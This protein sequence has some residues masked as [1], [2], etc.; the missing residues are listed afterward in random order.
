MRRDLSRDVTQNVRRNQVLIKA[1][2]KAGDHDANDNAW[3]VRALLKLFQKNILKLG[4]WRTALSIDK[5]MAKSYA[6]TS[7]KQFISGKPIRFGLKLWGF[8]TSDGFVLCFDLYC[9]KNWRIGVKFS[10]CA[11]G[12][13]VVMDL[14]EP[15]FNKTAAGKISQFRLYFD[16][17]FTNLDLIVHLRKLG[18]KCTRTIRDNRVKDVIDK[19]APRGEYDVKH[20]KNRGMNYMTVVDSKPVSI[21]TTASGVT[22]EKVQFT[23][24]IQS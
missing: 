6:R 21:V 7:F 4:V 10:K 17:Y 13:R 9:G 5:M 18:L 12:C 24:T 22:P 15:F 14:L 8:C 16:N 11:L 2:A 19:R 1:G 23:S 3:R 20:E